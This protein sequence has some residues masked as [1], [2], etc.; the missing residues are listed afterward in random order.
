M[1]DQMAV[2]RVVELLPHRQFGIGEAVEIH[3]A[4]K[5]DGIRFRRESL[6]HDLAGA[7]APPGPARHLHDQLEG[8]L[9]GTEIRHVHRQV[10]VDETDERDVGK[11]QP[12][13]DH[14]G[15]DEHI[16]L[17]GPEIAENLSEAVFLAHCVRVHPFQPGAR[18]HPAHRFLDALGAESAPADVRRGTC[19]TNCRRPALLAAQM[20]FQGFV[21]AMV[22]HRHAAMRALL[23]VSALPA[24]H[25]RRVTAAV[26]EQDDLFPSLKALVHVVHEQARERH[27]PALAHGLDP[28]VDDLDVGEFLV[29]DP[30]GQQIE[31]VFARADVGE[32]LQ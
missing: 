30:L 32:R 19:R 5:L 7:V 20:A 6:H 12:L 25:A 4:G 10:R 27:Q 26:D 11:I 18:Q 24:L 2:R 31:L 23:D 21:G 29:V 3:P 16:D 13:A 8:A 14:L 28:H 15:A 17:T 9:V 1:V 22:G